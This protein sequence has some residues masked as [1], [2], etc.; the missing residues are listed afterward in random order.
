MN[1]RGFVLIELIVVFGM[2]A[3]LIGM[4]VLNVFGSKQKASL[5]GVVDTLVADLRNQQT[6]AMS[7]VTQSGVGQSGYGIRFAANQYTLFNGTTYTSSDPTNVVITLDPRITFSSIQLPN[8]NVIFASKSGEF[9]GYSAAS[10]A[11]TAQQIDT[12]ETQTIHFDHYGII[13]SIN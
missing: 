12:H 8:N 4:T 13:T 11:L 1:K 9:I 7:G 3:V 6:K 5:T 2:M 10:S